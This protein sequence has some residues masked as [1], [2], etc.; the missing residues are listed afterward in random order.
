M[1]IRAAIAN[2]YSNQ[3]VGIPRKPVPVGE[4]F[5]NAGGAC[6]RRPVVMVRV[7]VTCPVGLG[8]TALG[9]N[10]QPASTGNPE[11]LNVTG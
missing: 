8:V 6:V 4:F 5:G 3:D 7:E 1:L 10:T 9:E 2:A 11:Q